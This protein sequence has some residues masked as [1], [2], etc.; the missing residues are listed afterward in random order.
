MTTNYHTPIANGASN[1]ASTWNTPLSALDS[2]ISAMTVAGAVF[3]AINNASGENDTTWIVDDSTGFLANAQVVWSVSG[4]T[5]SDTIVSVNSP[6]A[7]TV[8]NTPSVTLPDN[9]VI[10]QVPAG[11]VNAITG[12]VF[13]VSAYGFDNTGV[14]DCTTAMSALLSTAPTGSIIN[15]SAGTYYFASAF[16]IPAGKRFSFRGGGRDTQ[17][18]LAGT[19]LEMSSTTPVNYC[20]FSG[21]TFTHDG[22]STTARAFDQGSNDLVA[23]AYTQYAMAYTT[24]EHC[25]FWKT[26]QYGIYGDIILSHIDN[27]IFGALGA[28]DNMLAGVYLLGGD[29]KR[30]NQ[31]TVSRCVFQDIANGSAVA[32]IRAEGADGLLLDTNDIEGNGCPALVLSACMQSTLRSNWMERNN[33]GGPII[34]FDKSS[35]LSSDQ[36]V[37]NVTLS[38]NVIYNNETTA[39]TYIIDDINATQYSHNTLWYGNLIIGATYDF[40]S[41]II[42]SST[43]PIWWQGNVMRGAS[44]AKRLGDTSSWWHTDASAKTRS[45]VA[46]LHSTSAIREFTLFGGNL[47]NNISGP[48]V[49]IG[50]NT[51]ASTEGGAAGTMR[52]TNADGI[53]Y[54]FWVD[55]NGRLRI[56]TSAPTGDTGSPTVSDTAG[57]SFLKRQAGATGARPGSPNTGEPYFDTTLGYTIWYNGSN[58]VDATGATK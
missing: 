8:T 33:P 18:K 30:A 47:G 31:N 24:I 26:L 28:T 36:G 25:Y 20:H 46:E 17:I 42:E 29:G 48:Y 44:L 35:N 23:G 32:A 2:A 9:T 53:A 37:Y 50:R 56:H 34:R 11:I 58:W 45:L 43:N 1:A 39:N 10:S 52:L 22:S 27:C 4:V 12:K 15:F 19:W 51:S 49:S 6:T 40:S 7:I 5:Y 55:N 21:F 41:G 57:V 13:N 16:S 38:G 3:T 14:A 54:M